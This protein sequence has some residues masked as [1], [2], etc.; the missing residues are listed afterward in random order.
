MLG[1]A[2]RAALFPR[3]L[4]PFLPV[5]SFGPTVFGKTDPCRGKGPAE[6][7]TVPRPV[8][9]NALVTKSVLPEAIVPR[10]PWIPEMAQSEAPLSSVLAELGETGAPEAVSAGDVVEVFQHRSLGFLLTL[11]GLISALPIVG[12]IPGISILVATLI[13]VV[14][15]QS[16]VGGGSLWLPRFIRHR[17]LER[18]RFERSIEKARPWVEW[19]DGLL[20]PRLIAVVGGRTQRWTIS[21]AAMLLALAYYPLAFV[22]WGVTAPALGVLA[23]GLGMMTCDGVLVLFGYGLSAVT[24]YVLVISL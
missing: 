4:I 11:F 16:F 5:A 7:H 3:A 6:N 24:A 10:H 19:I 20:K 13:V 21:A 15:V 18:R 9:R 23:F 12:A 2:S 17:K 22:P 14:I 1:T 8:P